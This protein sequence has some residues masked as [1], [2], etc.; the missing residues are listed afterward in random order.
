MYPETRP[1]SETSHELQV[2][3]TRPGLRVPAALAAAFHAFGKFQPGAE[4][5][6]AFSLLAFTLQVIH[7]LNEEG[8]PEAFDSLERGAAHPL[9]LNV[10]ARAEMIPFALTVSR[11]VSAGDANR[12][13]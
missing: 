4:I 8:P 7:T 5:A 1:D 6:A 2:D 11:L 9:R 13:D 10:L 12:Q 3:L